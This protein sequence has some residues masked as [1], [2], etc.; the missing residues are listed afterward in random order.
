MMAT[1]AEGGW[2]ARLRAMPSGA[3]RT[4]AIAGLAALGAMW[5]TAVAIAGPAAAL[6]CVSLIACIFCIR[7]FRAGVVMLIVIMPISS[8]YVFP[9]SM[10]GITGLNPL[11][12]LLATTLCAYAM[13]CAGSGA[14]KG[15]APRPLVLLYVVPIVAGG[16]L[17]MSHVGLIPP[18]FL[19]LDQIEYDAPGGYLRDLVV[20]PLFLVLYALLVAA[21]VS[22]SRDPERY[23]TPLL[24][25]MFTMGVMVVGFTVASGVSLAEL[26]GSYSRSFF[27]PLGMHANDLGRLYATAYALLL[28]IWDRT[29]RPALKAVLV[30]TMGIVAIA[31]TLTFSR[32]AFIGF[33]LVNVIYLFSRRK[34]KTLLMGAMVVPVVL[35]FMPGAV[36]SRFEMGFGQGADAVSAGRVKEIWL[37][38]I[39][40]VLD[41]P[42]WGHG[43]Q[44]ILWSDAMR[45]GRI[46]EVT[47]PHSAFLQALL[48]TGLIG[49]ALLMMF[50]V[51]HVWKGFRRLAK[52]PL[53]SA[54][55]QG[56]FEGAA[57]GLLAFII[58][59][60]AGSSFFP[61]PEQSFLW[62][63]VGIMYGLRKRLGATTA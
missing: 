47:H 9:H 27:S 41:R 53:L 15:F 28:F 57:A 14:F 43:L 61:V 32:G 34:L 26:A 36:W 42:I 6:I 25:S 35:F 63:A 24:I 55:M 4:A 46:L 60:V 56:F 30:A 11:N 62:L 18:V 37:P 20:K 23:F 45:H 51:G 59:N 29:A 40:E 52:D 58:V 5:G 19:A 44:S 7:D 1:Y 38:L 22:R 48:D 17:G 2:G 54:E 33:I 3:R 50:W 39:P 10:F 49:L 13:N 31:L 8:S 16:L 12:L 21:G